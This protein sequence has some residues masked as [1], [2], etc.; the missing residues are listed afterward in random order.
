M[1]S[2]AVLRSV[3][4]ILA[5][6]EHFHLHM[7]MPKASTVPEYLKNGAVVRRAMEQL[8]TIDEAEVP[9]LLHG[10]THIEN[11]YWV[12]AGLGG[13]DI[14]FE[15]AWKSYRPHVMHGFLLGPDAR[16]NATK[17]FY[18]R[19]DRAIISGS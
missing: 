15:A 4:G 1:L 18:F 9:T 5:S 10:D 2:V 8:W 17:R 13:P 12:L 14:E 16:R 7:G 11:I 6:E 3:I 19:N